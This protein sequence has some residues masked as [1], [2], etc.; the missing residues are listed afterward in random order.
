M[1]IDDVSALLGQMHITPHRWGAVRASLTASAG[2]HELTEA[3]RNAEIAT[4]RR[5]QEAV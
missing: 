1:T 4:S 3:I 5:M 2:G